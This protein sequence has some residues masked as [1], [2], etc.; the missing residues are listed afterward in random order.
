L[1]SQRAED[2]KGVIDRP[3]WNRSRIWQSRG[4]LMARV[5]CYAAGYQVGMKCKGPKVQG[6]DPSRRR[7]C[8]RKQIR[9]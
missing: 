6:W 8:Q 2:L 3:E 5:H 1:V 4:E 7:V 9:K